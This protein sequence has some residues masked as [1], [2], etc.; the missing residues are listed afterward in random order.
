VSD[1]TTDMFQ[2]MHELLTSPQ[3]YKI[4]PVLWPIITLQ[5]SV[6]RL[7][8][9]MGSIPLISNLDSIVITR[10]ELD[11]YMLTELENVHHVFVIFNWE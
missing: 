6:G 11:L 2:S 3:E 9:I 7:I 8:L 10:K 1:L 5:A 4:T